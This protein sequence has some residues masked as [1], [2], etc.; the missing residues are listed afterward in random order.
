M[1]TSL[2]TRNFAIIL[3]KV[4]S[5]VTVSEEKIVEAMRLIWERV[6]IIIEPSSAVP[7]AAIL[8]SK[9]DVHNKRVGIILSGGNQDLDKLPFKKQ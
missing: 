3:D 9:V 8:E 7:L 1:L 2:G 6:K 5:I 4:D